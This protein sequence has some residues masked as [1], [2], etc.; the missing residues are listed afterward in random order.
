M[1]IAIKTLAV[2]MA[3]VVNSVVVA[4]IVVVV[5]PLASFVLLA[6]NP[7]RRIADGGKVQGKSP[8]WG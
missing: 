8:E 1:K 6:R 2:S 5:V 7:Y 3:K 4:N